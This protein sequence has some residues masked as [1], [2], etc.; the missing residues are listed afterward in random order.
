MKQFNVEEYHKNPSK[1]VVTRDGRNVQKNDGGI[2][3]LALC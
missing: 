1:K 2:Y 3:E